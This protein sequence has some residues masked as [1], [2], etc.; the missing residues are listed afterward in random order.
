ME[1]DD[2]CYLICLQLYFRVSAEERAKQYQLREAW[3]WFELRFQPTIRRYARRMTWLEPE[4]RVQELWLFLIPRL[5]KL[6]HDPQ[7]GP[8]APCIELLVRHA[9]S[10]A[11]RKAVVS[12]FETYVVNVL[13]DIPGNYVFG[14]SFLEHQELLNGIHDALSELRARGGAD[15]ARLIEQHWFGYV[16]LTTIAAES[17]RTPAQV[18]LQH[19]EARAKLKAILLYG[20]ARYVLPDWVSLDASSGKT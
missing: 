15:H 1:P 11:R 14:L 8:L 19:V 10:D 16:S 6:Q 17:G 9:V 13:P 12:P 3:E 5:L 18:R 20:R 4:A 2:T 7:R